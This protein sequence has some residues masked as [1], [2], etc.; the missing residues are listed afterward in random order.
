MTAL[1]SKWS[2]ANCAASLDKIAGMA[3]ALNKELD[4]LHRNAPIHLVMKLDADPAFMFDGIDLQQK[5]ERLAKELND[6]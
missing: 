6:G 2:H 1:R 4:A 3:L 5:C